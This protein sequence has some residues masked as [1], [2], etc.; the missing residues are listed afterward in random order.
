MAACRRRV[1]DWLLLVCLFL[2]AGC[3]T[4]KLPHAEHPDR[5]YMT[6]YPGNLRHAPGIWQ[7]V[8]GVD[9]RQW[10]PARNPVDCAAKQATWSSSLGGCVRKSGHL[11]WAAK[12]ERGF[13]VPQLPGV[14]VFHVS[15]GY[16]PDYV[17][18]QVT[19]MREANTR[20]RV[21][22]FQDSVSSLVGPLITYSYTLIA[23][24]EPPVPLTPCASGTSRGADGK[25]GRSR[26]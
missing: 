22:V 10:V 21:E 3:A 20:V 24:A 18:V 2:P 19:V 13:S 17:T 26:N 9:V 23:R 16:K 7:A 14:H 12:N 11:S 4:S 8:G 15:T 6:F 5:G 25:C 1:V